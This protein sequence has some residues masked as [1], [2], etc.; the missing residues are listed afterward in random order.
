MKTPL[1]ITMRWTQPKSKD[2]WI[3][4]VE[5]IQKDAYNQAIEE[6][7]ELLTGSGYKR[8]GDEILKLKK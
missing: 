7:A 5:Y 3:K 1:E 6:A 2:E 8:I 4:E